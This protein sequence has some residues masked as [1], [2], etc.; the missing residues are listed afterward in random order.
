M[1]VRGAIEEE[2]NLTGEIDRIDA[3]LADVTA[4]VDA[5]RAELNRVEGRIE[6]MKLQFDR[7]QMTC[8]QSSQALGSIK[9]SLSQ[10]L[11]EFARLDS[12]QR[13][14]TTIRFTESISSLNLTERAAL[15]AYTG[16]LQ[17]CVL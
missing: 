1:S 10:A 11:T 6:G 8:D 12:Q 5:K 14:E 7:M 3:D 9:E 2:I 17:E 4:Q 16:R 13:Q 15:L